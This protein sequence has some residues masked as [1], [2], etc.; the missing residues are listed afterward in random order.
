MCLSV[1]CNL[2]AQVQTE[3]NM[4]IR[5]G[6]LKPQVGKEMN[7]QENESSVIY[8]K[9]K[10]NRYKQTPWFRNTGSFLHFPYMEAF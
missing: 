5:G 3:G 10:K 4:P 7:A 1:W 6:N 2:A 9:L 8:L